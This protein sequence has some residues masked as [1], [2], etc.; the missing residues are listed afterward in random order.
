M[1]ISNFKKIMLSTIFLSIPLCGF[2][3]EYDVDYTNPAVE[4]AKYKFINNV[5]NNTLQSDIVKIVN[6]INPYSETHMD[7]ETKSSD[8]KRYEDAI[9]KFMQGNTVVAYKELYTALNKI[10]K[11]DFLYISVA[12]KF[13][14]IG[15]YTLATNAINLVE[16]NEIWG[17]Q[18]NLLKNN[19]FPSYTLSYDDEIYLAGLYS[20][21]YFHN[22][23][24]EVIKDLS[25][26]E[27][28]TKNSD[29]AN[30]LLSLAYYETKEYKQALSAVNKAIA[31]NPHNIN[32]QKNKAQILCELKDYK[33]ATKIIDT[34][35][36][37]ANN[38]VIDRKDLLA[39]KEYILA[40]SCTDEYLAK[41]HLGKYFYVKGDNT[42]ALK[43]LN[44]SLGPKKKY[45][46]AYALMGKIYT[47]NGNLGKAKE[48]YEKAYKLNKNDP[49]T[50]LGLGDLKF[51]EGNVQEA[52]NYFL[53]ATKKDKNYI[54]ALLYGAM[55]YKILNQP[56]VAKKLCEDALSLNSYMPDTYYVFSKIDTKESTMYLKKVTSYNPLYVDAWLDLA[57]NSIKDRNLELARTYLLPVKYIDS[58]NYKA[59]YYQGLIEKFDNRDEVAMYYFKK[60]LSIN[61][62]YEPALNEVKSEI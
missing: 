46:Q 37:E 2:C 17:K 10:Q 62:N 36:D 18:I 60:A 30:Y 45:Y 32:Y 15:F 34:L 7:N 21:I 42:R 56:D 61:P 33:Q 49:Q 57:Y 31:I 13:T 19:Y 6:S 35:T 25:K 16:D 50:L 41:Y 54:P 26:N 27:K 24:F 52:L 23:A 58:G 22:L 12:Y 8:Y 1:Q 40:K 44:Q 9:N 14:N 28:L 59:Y 55:C 4:A 3:T 51:K 43:S 29:Y 47:D 5:E 48:S 53:L 39:L 20:D 38:I 11:Q